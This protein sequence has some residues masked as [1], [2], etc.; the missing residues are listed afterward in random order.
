MAKFKAREVTL[1]DGQRGQSSMHREAKTP[2]VLLMSITGIVLLIACANIANLLLARTAA[3][4]RELAVRCCLGASPRR[5][6][7]Q[8]LTESVL[9]SFGGAA[10]GALLAMWGTSALRRL[11]TAQFPRIDEVRVDVVVLA[12]TVGV[13]LIT[14]LLC[15]LVPAWR[16]TRVDLQDAMKSGAKGSS[17]PG[18]RRASNG[19][20][21]GQ[22]ALSLLLLVG[23]GLLLRSYHRLSSV[24]TG[25]RPDNA[26]VARVS[27]PYP[28]YG[29]PNVVRDFYTRLLEQVRV[30]P[31]VAAAGMASR[32]PLSPGNQQDGIEAEGKESATGEGKVVANIRM[33]SGDYFAAMGTP[34]L[35]GRLF[36]QSDDANT[37]RVA[38]VD[39]LF[40]KHFWPGDDALGKRFR[41]GGDTTAGRWLT[42]IG[43]VPNVKHTRLDETGDLQV[44]E[45][46]A[47][48]P[49][50]GNFLVVRTPTGRDDAGIV[51]EIRRAL[52]SLDPSIPLFEV[53]SMREAVDYSLAV[54][55]LM[56]TLLVGFSLTALLLAAIGI[57]GVMSLGV[58]GRVREFGIR[59]ALGAKPESV[60]GL[61]L[62][63]ATWLAFAGIVAGLIGA[64]ATTRYL[65]TLLFGVE[66]LDTVTFGAVALLLAATALAA[67]YLPARRATRADPMTALRSE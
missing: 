8:L 53:R 58:S 27:L 13:A 42:V 24:D 14:G 63:Q 52:R 48:R 6:A 16:A 62:R 2:L 1:E 47:Q 39:E 45:H 37:P 56:N 9:L 40:A 36:R 46:F 49:T 21:V 28:R 12:V 23:A 15:G 11:P 18:S 20:V 54:R 41:H 67:S 29:E 32:V 55:R 10:L 38:V 61:V 51:P 30:I 31:G 19:F 57:Y 66:P 50:W 17:G 3:R 4:G 44:Y 5:I 35:R 22:F 34:L 60:R 59:L 33:V 64:V 43:V 26:L 25:Y 7:A 65:R